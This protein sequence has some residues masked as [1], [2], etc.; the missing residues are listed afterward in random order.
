[1]TDFDGWRAAYDEGLDELIGRY[2][3]VLAE[4]GD[5]VATRSLTAEIP[6]ALRPSVAAGLLSIAVARLARQEPTR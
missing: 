5:T 3:E 6:E 2:R 1:V 4:E